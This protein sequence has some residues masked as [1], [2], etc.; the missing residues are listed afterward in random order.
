[1]NEQVHSLTKQLTQFLLKWKYR[2]MKIVMI[3]V[4]SKRDLF[5]VMSLVNKLLINKY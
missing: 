4:K 1:M 5:K 3:V 2:T